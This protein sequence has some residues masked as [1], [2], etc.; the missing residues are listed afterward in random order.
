MILVTALDD[1][2]GMCFNHRRQSKDRELRKKLMELVGNNRFWMNIYSGKQ[3]ADVDSANI[4]LDE[5][6][7]NKAG[8]G[9]YCFVEDKPLT[10]LDDRIEGL[11]LFLWNRTYPA[12]LFFDLD[13]EDFR[14]CGISD[15]PGSSHD[16]ITMEIWEKDKPLNCIYQEE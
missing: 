15:F 6:F 10:G 16:K 1:K 9:E 4:C 8:I 14:L 2:G 7:L 3:F 11:V 12:D 5:D 13:M